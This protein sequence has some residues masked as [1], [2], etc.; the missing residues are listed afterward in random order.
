MKLHLPP[1]R[2]T[3]NILVL[4]GAAIIM[5]AIAMFW[6][7]SLSGDDVLQ[8]HNAPIPVRTIREHPTADGVVILRVDYCKKVDATGR[9]RVS[10]VSEDRELFLPASEDRDKKG[11]QNRE[12]PI[13]IPSDTPPGTYVIRFRI[14]Y[15]VNP[16]KKNIVEE[17]QSKPFEVVTQ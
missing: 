10:F 17:F 7:W 13:L 5:A 1:F 12:V 4:A 8:V 6:Y 2:K 11:C 15:D 14:I 3:L 9:A 16:L